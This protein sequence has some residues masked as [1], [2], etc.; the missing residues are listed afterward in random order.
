MRIH[1]ILFASCYYN[2]GSNSYPKTYCHT[3]SH[4]H[5]LIISLQLSA[6]GRKNI[7]KTSLMLTS[8][9][10]LI[11]LAIP[12]LFNKQLV[13]MTASIFSCCDF[14]RRQLQLEEIIF[15]WEMLSFLYIEHSAV[16]K[17]SHFWRGRNLNVSSIK[18]QISLSGH[19]LSKNHIPLFSFLVTLFGLHP[20]KV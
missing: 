12:V 1:H 9:R 5:R 6:V 14:K 19:I 2:N 11:F 8:E 17:V 7:S 20:L 10:V 4:T 18:R 15:N 13:Y 16:S 3:F